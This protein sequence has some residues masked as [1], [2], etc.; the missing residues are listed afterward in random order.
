MMDGRQNNTMIYVAALLIDR[1]WPL[2][3]R[4][5]FFS[6]IKPIKN[7]DKMVTK[8]LFRLVARIGDVNYDLEQKGPF[9]LKR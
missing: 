2:R 5:T 4:A 9:H 7:R 6:R 3:F 8:I 1:S